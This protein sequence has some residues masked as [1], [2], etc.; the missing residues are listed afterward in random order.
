MTTFL[1]IDNSEKIQEKLSKVLNTFENIIENGA[2]AP[3]ESK[4]SIS[5]NI[6]KSVIFQRCCYG[7]MG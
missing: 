4:Y 2:I 3:K 5:H 1:F 7:V 6:F